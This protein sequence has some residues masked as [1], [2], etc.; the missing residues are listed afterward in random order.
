MKAFVIYLP[1][2]EHSK[3]HANYMIN[4]LKSYN[5]DAMLF[6]GTPGD[7]GVKQAE[8][9]KKTLYPYSIK[10]RVVDSN[11]IDKYLKDHLKEEFKEKYH[12]RLFERGLVGDGDK[13]KLSRPGVIGCFYSHYALWQKC[14]D[15]NEPIMIFED[16]VKFYRGFEP[17]QWDDVLILWLGKS[18]FLGDPLAVLTKPTVLLAVPLVAKPEY[19]SKSFADSPPTV[20]S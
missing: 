10:N 8:K 19:S 5:I 3:N 6:E 9:A 11:E 18:S 1:D 15:L 7:V 16:D 17:V 2:R 14:I 13:G 12:V 20:M 4:T